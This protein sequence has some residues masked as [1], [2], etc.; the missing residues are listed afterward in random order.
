M[1]RLC[2]FAA[3]LAV[4]GAAPS[5]QAQ[6]AEAPAAAAPVAEVKPDGK[7]VVCRKAVPTG[8][9]TTTAFI[10]NT[11]DGWR[12]RSDD[13]V[14]EY[15]EEPLAP[16]SKSGNVKAIEIGTAKWDTMP[17]LKTKPGYLPYSALTRQMSEILRKNLC[18]MPGQ[19][20]R[21]F[22]VEVPYAAM[23]A[24]DGTASRVLVSEMGCDALEA[25]VGGAVIARADRGDFLPTGDA[26]TRWFS[27]KMVLIL[28]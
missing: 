27:D 24:P 11:R 17:A 21:S 25:M 8:S 6:N 16:L 15:R 9:V 22:A 14:E 7:T 20:A 10:C 13:I 5:L 4:A 12:K 19:T 18:K 23:V 26:K 3:L 2:M 1:S 28:Q